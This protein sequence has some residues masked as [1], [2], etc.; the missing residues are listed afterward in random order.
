MLIAVFA[1][2]H[3]NRQAFDACLA[4]ARS[5][6]AERNVL[7]GDYVGYGAD[8]EWTVTTVL[9]LV[10]KGAIAVRGNH[11]NAVGD[12]RERLN[13]E[14]SVAIEWTRGELGTAER[15]FLAELPLTARDDNRLYVHADA[16]SPETWRY[17]TNVSAAARSMIATSA[18][19]TLCG[20]VHQPALYTMSATGKTTAF[21]PVSGSAIQLL[22][23]RRWLAVL[24]SVG[25]PRDGNP[26]ASYVMLDTERS[27][28]TY[29]RAPYDV[30]EAATRIRK[31]GLP[32]WLADRLA[33]GR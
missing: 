25:Q 31:K 7:L 8:P 2:I 20:H 10:D 30:A 14:A 27:E 29:C 19:I 16:S 22:P 11:D 33:I 6:G 32:A 21:T 13:V 3:A 1:D 9:D 18:P 4:Q 5:F 23:S 15:R 17:V 12:L 28:L 26:A 24:G